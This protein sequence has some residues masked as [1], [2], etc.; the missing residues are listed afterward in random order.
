M[1]AKKI[2]VPGR[3]CL[4]GEH[5]D[6]ASEYIE[7]NSNVK[8]GH[9]IVACLEIG[10]YANIEKNSNE[11]VLKEK[12]KELRIK[13]DVNEIKKEIEKN[14]YYAFVLTTLMHM[15]VNYE[16]D[17]AYIEIN[18]NTLPQKK[19]FSSSASISVL[20]CRTFN[21]LYNL[22]LS[23]DDEMNI[24]YLCER[25]ANSKCGKM[26]Q[27]VAL[28][29][30][31]YYMNFHNGIVNY[32]NIEISENIYM[33]YADLNSN[34][35]TKKILS[36]LHEAYPFPKNKKEEYL[37][38]YLGEYNEKIV[39]EAITLF[40][41][42]DAKS[43][44]KLMSKAQR[45][46]DKY[47]MPLS[48]EELKAPKLH[49]ILNDEG[50]KKLS[51][52]GKGVGAQGDGSIQFI[53]EDSSKQKELIKYLTKK[54]SI[55]AYSLVIKKNIDEKKVK[56]AI[57]PLA[58]LGTRMYP[59]T[60]SIPKSFIPIVKDNQFKP[61]IQILVEELIDSGIE[62][63]GLIINKNQKELY[64]SFFSKLE[65]GTEYLSRIEFLYQEKQLGL[66]DAILCAK[67]MINEEPFLLV[68]GDQFYHSNSN[69]TCTKQLL[70]TYEKLKQNVISVY[71]VDLKD[72]E[73]YGVFFGKTIKNNTYKITNILE[74]PSI[75]LAK[76]N[77]RFKNEDDY[78][79]A[80]GEY[81]LD[82]RILKKLNDYKKNNKEAVIPFTE[83]LHEVYND[84]YAYIVDGEMYDI[85]NVESYKE[86]IKRLYK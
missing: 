75:E 66:G 36:D 10:I 59:F 8:D 52:G 6:W 29:E 65:K 12:D 72:V 5:S 27:I 46:F 14:P 15:I 41:K 28:N 19:G 78:Y 70:D 67:K 83:F 68:L 73:H 37:I 55:N 26:D 71:K 43:L 18:K 48:L 74:K 35:N 24:A 11:F 76:N 80:F 22:G 86:T 82:E 69:K 47:A 7:K 50:V 57:I 64:E 40:K 61:I 51:L 21:I 20:V 16:V 45:L 81:I 77:N 34:R 39:N 25:Y 58:G 79:I 84:I 60:L 32:K 42:G 2:F 31:A 53:V 56:K 63:I 44:G 54:L 1:K 33:V 62:K 4:F 13:L 49:S 85:G 3:L 23:H 9:T 17:G 30:G 38:K